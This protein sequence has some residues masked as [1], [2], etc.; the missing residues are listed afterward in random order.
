FLS[1]SSWFPVASAAMITLLLAF[2]IAG[3]YL[4]AAACLAP[5]LALLGGWA[6][7]TGYPGAAPSVEAGEGL[8][9]P[10]QYACRNAPG[11]WAVVVAMLIVGSLF[12][13]LVFGYFYLWLGSDAWPPP[14]LDD[15][16]PGAMHVVALAMLPL[17][18]LGGAMATAAMG[19]G[20]RRRRRVVIPAML[21]SAAAIAFVALHLSLLAGT[22]GEPQVHAYASVVWTLAGFCA[23]HLLVAALMCLHVCARIG[24]RLVDAARPL[25]WRVAHAYLRYA[26]VQAA[27]AWAVIH[28][29]PVLQ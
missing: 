19:A 13:S 23:V 20:A 16:T 4:A 21:G 6:W 22:T 9:L 10:S 12:A 24:R 26:V 7:T 14:G 2:F 1:S 5:L 28:L 11:W 25:E 18:W 17:A 3:W 27:I 29:F 8:T 15:G